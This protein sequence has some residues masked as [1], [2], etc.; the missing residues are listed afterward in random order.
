[1]AVE[2]SRGGSVE[3]PDWLIDV[4]AIAQGA[5]VRYADGQERRPG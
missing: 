1:V 4:I 5:P 2:S 3:M